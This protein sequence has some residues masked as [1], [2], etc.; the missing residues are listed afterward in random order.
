MDR[1]VA[2]RRRRS[3]D[4]LGNGLHVPA[5]SADVL[6]EL[7]LEQIDVAR[8]PE[9]LLER[10]RFGQNGPRAIRERLART[11]PVEHEAEAPLMDA[12]AE[13]EE[14]ASPQLRCE[15]NRNR[16]A[17][18]AA[19]E[20]TDVV[21]LGHDEALVLTVLQPSA[22]PQDDRAPFERELGRIRVRSVD[23]VRLAIRLAVAET[24]PVAP[25][26]EVRDD[27]ELLAFVQQRLLERDVVP[28]RHEELVR[29][30]A[31]TQASRQRGEETMGARRNGRRL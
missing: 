1:A 31:S 2:P 15:R 12:I 11:D 21:V 8:T 24:P 25:R 23:D 9:L 18:V 14:M 19:R 28:R 16:S 29:Q 27:V 30:A 7:Q 10:T 22:Q 3:C 5:E 20:I 26:R 6:V 17:D 4:R 13:E